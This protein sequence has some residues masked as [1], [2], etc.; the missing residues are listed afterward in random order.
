MTVDTGIDGSLTI[1]SPSNRSCRLI[2]VCSEPVRVEKIPQ[3]VDPFW[4][5]YLTGYD[6]PPEDLDAMNQV[7]IRFRTNLLGLAQYDVL[8]AILPGDLHVVHQV[9]DDTGLYLWYQSTEH[10][11]RL[12]FVPFPD[13]Q[14]SPIFGPTLPGKPESIYVMGG[15]SLGTIQVALEPR[16]NEHWA[17]VLN[18]GEHHS[19]T[20]AG[21]VSI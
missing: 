5:D 13:T 9:A 12:V 8:W 15:E 2:Q 14:S 21:S 17:V 6:I 11:L 19:L 20:N 1:T 7:D 4:H 18:A 16:D 10:D 3:P